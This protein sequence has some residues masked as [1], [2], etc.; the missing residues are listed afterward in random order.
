M[1]GLIAVL[2]ALLVTLVLLLSAVVLGLARADALCAVCHPASK[3]S[4]G[5][6]G[7]GCYRCHAEP[8][9]TARASRLAL[10]AAYAMRA[11]PPGPPEAAV[12]N[13]SC[14][15]CH[16]DALTS[17]PG[18]SGVAMNHYACL[19]ASSRCTDCHSA[20]GHGRV[21]VDRTPTMDRCSPC[22]DGTT[23]PKACDTCHA[24]PTALHARLRAWSDRHRANR[25]E[26]TGAGEPATCLLCHDRNECTG[27][28]L[29]VPHGPAWPTLHGGTA[30]RLGARACD[31]CHDSRACYGCHSLRR[32]HPGDWLAGHAARAAV[33]GADSIC[34]Y[35]HA[36]SD[37]TD[38]HAQSDSEG[39]ATSGTVEAQP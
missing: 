37:C 28:H 34:A 31:L 30:L 29:A 6:A 4:G 7:I 17:S 38:C 26:T 14:L 2:A 8:G 22:H 19:R 24:D 21:S 20:A 9:A 12:S 25:H 3:V 36:D 15:A 18:T 39:P 32:T 23:A 10:D 16:A 5:H 27:C 1:R 13:D 11:D 35:C 33:A